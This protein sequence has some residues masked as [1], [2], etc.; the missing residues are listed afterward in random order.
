[1]RR[2]ILWLCA[3]PIILSTIWIC[4]NIFLFLIPAIGLINTEGSWGL[5]CSV[6]FVIPF[7]ACVWLA[8]REILMPSDTGHLMT[9]FL[10][11][12]MGAWYAL[13]FGFVLVL[14]TGALILACMRTLHRPLP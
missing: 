10:W 2:V 9:A 5:F 6:V 14:L 12:M 1:M 13:L 7:A 11:Q 3:T 4:I 8:K